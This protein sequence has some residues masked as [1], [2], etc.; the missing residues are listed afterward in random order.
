MYLAGSTLQC[1]S[2]SA[3]TKHR[4]GVM[5]FAMGLK[6]IKNIEGFLQDQEQSFY[7]INKLLHYFFN[8]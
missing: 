4:H 8:M 7:S 5:H 1:A 3:E 2:P 6:K